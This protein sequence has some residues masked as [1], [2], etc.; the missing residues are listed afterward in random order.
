MTEMT[1]DPSIAHLETKVS[2]GTL[3]I[4]NKLVL[5]SKQPP[6]WDVYLINVATI[7]RNNLSRDR[8]DTAVIRGTEYDVS[9]LITYIDNY[10][11]TTTGIAILYFGL[12]RLGIPK[13]HRRTSTTTRKKI[14]A[15]TSEI[16]R[17]HKG[18]SGKLFDL[19]YA[20][21]TLRVFSINHPGQLPY[22]FLANIL[23]YTISYNKVAL[24]T[25]DA[26]DMLM[27]N[28]LDKVEVL[29]SHTGYILRKR[30]L[31][32]KVFKNEKIPLNQVTLRLFGDKDNIIPIIRN[33]PK[34]LSRLA[35]YNLHQKTEQEIFGIAV[36]TL[37][38]KKQLL[39]YK[40]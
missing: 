10:L 8:S 32:F 36:N 24:L 1:Y 35:K 34:A 25:H 16:S 40:F 28:A 31:G 23:Q 9:E 39:Q 18:P 20:S 29:S 14:A 22:R 11:Q 26:T 13:E 19:D 7:V 5:L 2:Y 6:R 21:K 30:D 15:L 12:Q 33:K 4:I 38:V 27:C 3:G 37:G 17:L